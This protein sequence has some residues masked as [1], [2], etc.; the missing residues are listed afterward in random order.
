MNGDLFNVD[1]L[2]QV[3]LASMKQLLFGILWGRD[4]G[5]GILVDSQSIRVC[6]MIT[7]LHHKARK[8]SKLVFGSELFFFLMFNHASSI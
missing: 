1:D 2:Q 6:P 7:S 5:V 4:G 3:W 8:G